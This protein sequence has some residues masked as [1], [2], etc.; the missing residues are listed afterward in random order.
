MGALAA[1]E[2]KRR[3]SQKACTDSLIEFH[4]QAWPHIDP[5]PYSDNWHLH[6]IAEHLEA[7][8]YGQI[9]RL[10]I[11]IPPRCSKSLMV[12]VSWLA[13]TWAQESDPEF[14]LA[15]PSVS[16]LCASYAQTLS[17]RDSLKTHRLIESPWYQERWGKKFNFMADK[18]TVRKFENNK[19]G[20]RLATSVGGSL[21]GEGASILCVVAGERV[22]TPRGNVPIEKIVA[23]DSVLAFD[24]SRETVQ[25]GVVT[26]TANRK[27]HGRVTIHTT[28]GFSVRVSFEHTVFVQGKGYVQAGTLQPGDRLV[29]SRGSQ[30]RDQSAM[31][32]VRSNI[33]E[34]SIRSSQDTQDQRSAQL[35]RDEM[36]RDVSFT[37]KSSALQTLRGAYS[38]QWSS[39]LLAR[40]RGGQQIRKAVEAS[41]SGMRALWRA[42]SHQNFQVSTSILYAP[43]CGRSAFQS[44]DRLGQLPVFQGHRASKPYPQDAAY[45]FGTGR[46]SLCG[47]L[48][49]RKDGLLRKP[50]A[51][52]AASASFGRE[53]E[54]QRSEESSDALC[55]MSQDTPSWETGTISAIEFDREAEYLAYDLSVA[56]YRNFFAGGILVHNSVDDSINAKEANYATIREAANR[57]WDESMSTRLNNQVSGAKVLTMQ[58][59]H[60]D[61]LVGHILEKAKD[62]DWCR[63][64]IPMEFDGDWRGTTTIGW[65]DPRQFEGELLWPERFPREVVDRLKRD[66]GPYAAS[67]QL[68]QS[69]SPRAGGIIQRDWW[70]L[71]PA[72][73]YEPPL[74]QKAQYP[75]TSLRIG[76]VDTAYGDK[77][78]NAWNAMTVWGIW[79]DERERPKV[80]MMDAWRMRGPLRGVIPPECKTDDE[81][82]PHWGLSEKIAET[83]RKRQLDIVLIEDKTRGKDLSHEI[84]R[85]LRAGECQ[86][87]LINPHGGDKVARLHACQ[88]MFADRMIYAPDTV[89]AEMVITEVSQFPKSKWADF[90]DTC[91]QALQYMR[92]TGLL[93]MGTEADADNIQRNTF[94]SRRP[95]RYDI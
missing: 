80:V 88:A 26:N 32:G 77:D 2:L 28:A 38:K 30:V 76:S 69:P 4:R 16:M 37:E 57:W 62:E 13:W 86:I 31:R 9:P 66:L 17:E 10:I 63:L 83:I 33:S 73:G 54:E 65:S 11:S 42:V 8:T 94:V 50:E 60:E 52:M 22:L 35:L 90:T 70:Q 29:C 56:R 51:P 84:T 67:A 82:R 89:W 3:R 27:R 18:D 36:P 64:I 72:P 12:S 5:A 20:Y 14:P 68:Q 85:L 75:A 81:R 21:T 24:H 87:L 58:R 53:P 34:A 61:D 48:V 45:D 41:K 91:S 71:W 92:N 44:H 15:G 40:L 79:Q 74:G 47:L 43:V 6:A 7:V 59:L 39:V 55:G 95:N 78:E 93:Q 19:G 46:P 23:G 25:V 1:Q 49:S